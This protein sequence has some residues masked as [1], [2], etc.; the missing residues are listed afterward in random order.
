MNNKVILAALAAP[1]FFGGIQTSASASTCAVGS[2]GSVT[3]DVVDR[4]T[5]KNAINA[6]LSFDLVSVVNANWNSIYQG[7][8][9]N[10]DRNNS[11][12]TGSSPIQ[13]SKTAGFT[14]TEI[15]A[16]LESQAFYTISYVVNIVN[17]RITDALGSVTYL[18][19]YLIYD[20]D[21]VQSYVQGYKSI[22]GPAVSLGV[23]AVPGPEAG[24]GLGAVA[25]GGLAL[26][27]KR[28]RK[29]PVAA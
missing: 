27:M 22:V 16:P 17:G 4:S 9:Y 8:Q 12:W 11:T 23:T 20:E 28:R 1:L 18:G 7:L 2:T 15:S 25:L 26:Y 24:A 14:I 19:A 5:S 10:L 6:M 29:E 13:G 21:G 3:C